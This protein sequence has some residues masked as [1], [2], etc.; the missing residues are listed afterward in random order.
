MLCVATSQLYVQQ[1]VNLN[2]QDQLP[3]SERGAIVDVHITQ[4]QSAID[5][6]LMAGR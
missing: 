4:F 5:T 2:K 3:V 1:P 6:M